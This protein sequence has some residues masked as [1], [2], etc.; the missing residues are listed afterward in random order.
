MRDTRDEEKSQTNQEEH[1]ATLTDG[2]IQQSSL[3]LPVEE[4][5]VPTSTKLDP[6]S[7]LDR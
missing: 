4:P 1:R 7:L 6:R 2:Q 3:V 5:A